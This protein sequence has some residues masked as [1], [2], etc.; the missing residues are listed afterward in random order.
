MMNIPNPVLTRVCA[1]FAMVSITL[2][3]SAEEQTA[4]IGYRGSN[5]TFRVLSDKAV[6]ASSNESFKVTFGVMNMATQEVFLS[7]TG[8]SNLGYYIHDNSRLRTGSPG[9]LVC[10]PDNTQLLKRL[11]AARVIQ[12]ET[13]ACG[14][15]IA[16]IQGTVRLRKGTLEQWL[17]HRIEVRLPL[18]GFVRDT[19]ESFFEEVYIP[20]EIDPEDSPT[21]QS[22]LSAK[23]GASTET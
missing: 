15:A 4:A 1:V 23:A 10:F 18:I 2:Y 17:G 3:S 22:T 14:C 6:Y 7:V 11:H 19:G 9:S 21:T 5:V 20:F 16:D 12:G 13:N 8:F